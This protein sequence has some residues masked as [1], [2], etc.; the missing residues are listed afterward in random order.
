MKIERISENQIRCTLTG[1]DLSSRNLNLSELAYGSEKAR[2]LFNEMIEKAYN[3]T[4]FEADDIPVMVEAIPLSGENIMLLITKIDDPEELDTRF[5]RF[6]P[7]SEDAPEAAPLFSFSTDTLEGSEDIFKILNQM[8]PGDKTSDEQDDQKEA[9]ET[10]NQ[11]NPI[12]I[13]TFN[14]LDQVE[15][16]AAVCHSICDTYNSLYKNP[17]NG[18][19]YLYLEG[20]EEN[21]E[22][23]VKLCNLLSEYGSVS[24]ASSASVAYMEEHYE[25]FIRT[26]ALK[27]LSSI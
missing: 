15:T 16:A 8:F 9:K 26:N 3:E 14:K 7:F 22:A 25:R 10:A 13:F 18:K 27:I 5:S 24:P 12:R 19:Y 6:S 2:L 17:V 23:F 11:Q 20:N 21:H 1:A 4:G